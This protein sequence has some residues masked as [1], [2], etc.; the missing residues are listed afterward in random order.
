MQFICG[1]YTKLVGI[2]TLT[3]KPEEFKFTYTL[4]TRCITDL[5][6]VLSM[7]GHQDCTTHHVAEKTEVSFSRQGSERS[8]T[9]KIKLLLAA[10][11]VYKIEHAVQCEGMRQHCV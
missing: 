2:W 7:Q 11:Q 9:K 3:A 6:Y 1:L 5:K 8:M 10:L 4:T